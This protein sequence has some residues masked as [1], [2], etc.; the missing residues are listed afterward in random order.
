MIQGMRRIFLGLALVTAG[1]S[2]ANADQ[3]LASFNFRLEPNIDYQTNLTPIIGT[4]VFVKQV[5][6][7]VFGNNCRLAVGALT[8]SQSDRGPLYSVAPQ[9]GGVYVLNSQLAELQLPFR[10]T[11]NL[12]A[13]CRIELWSTNGN[14]P[15]P[16][17]PP[18]GDLLN[19]VTTVSNDASLLGLVIKTTNGYQSLTTQVTAVSDY[20]RY[21]LDAV[22]ANQSTK[23]L[24]EM[25]TELKNRTATFEKSFLQVHSQQRNQD[26]GDSWQSYLKALDAVHL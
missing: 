7:K 11:R 12:E 22:K 8:F 21:F 13:N 4:P 19:R 5:Q 16:N 3:L 14:N 26:V 25:Y 1:S 6:A 10:Q 18:T 20:A 23:R 24:S 17:P 15:I 2:S 9:A